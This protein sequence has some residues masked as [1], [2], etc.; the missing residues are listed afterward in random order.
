MRSS[1]THLSYGTSGSPQESIE[2]LE[3]A[4][5][6]QE[7]EKN[8]K[9]EFGHPQYPK[10][11]LSNLGNTENFTQG[12]IKHIF[13]GEINRKGEATGYH[14]EGV[15]NTAG[16]VVPGTRTT[17]DANGVYRG[18]VEVNGVSKNGFSTFF[19]REMSPQQVVN[20]INRRMLTEVLLLVL[21]INFWERLPVEC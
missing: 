2:S 12:A 1:N 20:A 11:T 18:K 3:Y 19:P 9:E 8:L 14:Y 10:E 4:A 7:I 16:A 6:V 17:P 21:L 5:K 13:E 15:E